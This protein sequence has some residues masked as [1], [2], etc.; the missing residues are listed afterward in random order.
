MYR[1]RDV[2]PFDA[3]T[4]DTATDGLCVFMCVMLA[5]GFGLG[6]EV[7]AA[8]GGIAWLAWLPAR[9]FADRD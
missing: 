6:S 1:V 7:F 4:W 3:M 2:A 9:F 5:I 8:L